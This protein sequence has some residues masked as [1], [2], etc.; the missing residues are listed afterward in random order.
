[1]A[2]AGMIQPVER[3]VAS[4]TSSR[5]T[6]PNHW[7]IGS[8]RL[9]RSVR[10]S[11]PWIRYQMVA[12]AAAA[13]STSQTWMRFRKRAATGN[14]RKISTRAKPTWTGRRIVVGTMS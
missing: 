9:A 5:K 4:S 8:G 12:I 3:R 6:T 13:S 2:T 11:P 1:M 14:I 7:S 10:S